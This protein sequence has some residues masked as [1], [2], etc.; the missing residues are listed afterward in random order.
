MWLWRLLG[1]QLPQLKPR[2]CLRGCR[3]RHRCTAGRGE[4][5]VAAAVV[6]G[7]GCGEQLGGRWGEWKP[8]LVYAVS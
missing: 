3:G 6:R 2:P 1:P 4:A 8:H 5:A 7:A